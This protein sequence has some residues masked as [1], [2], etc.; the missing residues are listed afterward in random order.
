MLKIV[1]V[2]I[3]GFIEQLLYTAYILSVT[4]KKVISSSLLMFSYMTIYLFLIAYAL[5]DAETVP[6]LLSYALSCGVGNY[7]V[8]IWEKHKDNNEKR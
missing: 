7:V 2:F 6:M 8:M 4:K 1:L 3:V 5:K